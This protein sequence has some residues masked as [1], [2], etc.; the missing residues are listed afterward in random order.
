MPQA[1]SFFDVTSE[2]ALIEFGRIGISRGKRTEVEKESKKQV[3]RISP[4]LI[5][6]V[7][8]EYFP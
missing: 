7:V 4:C 5:V 6:A 2:V 3:L 1:A 8:R